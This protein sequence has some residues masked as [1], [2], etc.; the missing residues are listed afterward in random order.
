MDNKIT[1]EQ[2]DLAIESFHFQRMGQKTC[3]GICTLKNG[4]EL[5]ESASCVDP[6]SYDDDAGASLVLHR[7]KD[8]IYTLLGYDLHT[9]LK[10]KEEKASHEKEKA[11]G[12]EPKA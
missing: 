12:N 1:A 7:I 4:F 9:K 2:V 8:K 11:D 5:V 3:V 6:A 10:A